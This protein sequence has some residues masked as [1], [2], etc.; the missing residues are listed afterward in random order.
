MLNLSESLKNE[1]PGGLIGA[2]Q[3][4]NASNTEPSQSLGKM[5]EELEHTLRNHYGG[6]NRTD[7]GL[8]EPIKT[9]VDY[10]KRFRKT[11][12]VLLQL[13][14]V[15][16]KNKS[17]PNVSPLVT[18][19]FMAE[20]KNQYLTA[21]HD[22]EMINLPI[23]V[24]LSQGSERYTL[25]NGQEKELIQGDMMMADGNRIISSIVYGP[26]HLTQIKKNTTNV[27]Y[28]VYAP[29]GIKEDLLGHHL[30]DINQYV[31]A[32]SPDAVLV[33][34]QTYRI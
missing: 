13:E 20:L 18:A 15:V 32:A 27:L 24:E 11:Y 5:K 2:V 26:D 3:F 30:Q 8:T 16:F 22:L 14:S 17:I 6:L 21:G 1:Y 31:K 19:M 28:V 25:L 12:H 10:Y 34:Q 4:K 7:L 33:L 29:P 9:Y 23:R